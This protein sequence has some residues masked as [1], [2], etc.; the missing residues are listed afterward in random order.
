MKYNEFRL[1][2]FRKTLVQRE[3]LINWIKRLFY[4]NESLQKEYD[5][6]YQQMYYIILQELISE[7]ILYV[8]KVVNLLSNDTESKNY[9][10]FNS[11]LNSLIKI[12]KL[13]SED[14]L[15]FIEYKRHNACHIFQNHYERVQDNGKFKY[16]R[17]NKDILVLQ[18]K[19]QKILLKYNGDKGFDQYLTT[20]LHSEISNIFIMLQSIKNGEKIIR[21]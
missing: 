8:Q 5:S 17:K 14:E 9:K 21:H 1:E 10:W 4:L 20:S 13:F 16:E 3:Q 2:V 15:D 18:I 7:G 12:K 11:L 6:F 19:F